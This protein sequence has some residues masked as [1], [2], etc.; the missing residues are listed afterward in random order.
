MI[1]AVIVGF[2]HMHVNEIAMYIDEQ[3][4]MELVGC[5]EIQPEQPEIGRAH[6]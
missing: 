3:P 4:D 1:R 2:A 6:V 5:A